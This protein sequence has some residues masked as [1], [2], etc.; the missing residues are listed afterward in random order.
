MTFLKE[1]RNGSSLVPSLV[2]TSYQSLKY[3]QSIPYSRPIL[4]ECSL[5]DII[6]KKLLS[7]MGEGLMIG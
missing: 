7:W 4:N 1:Q 6:H 5:G 2:S 3:I